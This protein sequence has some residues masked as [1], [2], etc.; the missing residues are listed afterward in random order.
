ME[1]VQYRYLAA[2]A[3]RTPYTSQGCITSPRAAL[4][5]PANEWLWAGSQTML[6]LSARVVA[7]LVN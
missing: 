6:P 7:G 4:Q 5:L 2:A 3:W 1:H